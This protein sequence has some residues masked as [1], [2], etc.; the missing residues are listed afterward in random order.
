[1]SDTNRLKVSE[2][3]FDTIKADLKSFMK[4][5][6][7][8]EDYNFEGSALSSMLDVMS[9]VTH[10]NAI[11]AN[12]AINETFLDSARLR[13]S[14]VSHAKMLGYTPRSSYP[15]VAYLTIEVNNPSGVLAE[16]GSYLPLIMTK[17]T[18]FTSTID[19]VSY[20]FVND[21]TVTTTRDSA[22]KYIFTNIKILQGSYKS[23]EYVY[24]SASAEAYVIPFDNAVTSELTVKIKASDSNAATETFESAVNVTA[25]TSASKVYFLEESRTGLF[26]VKFGDG[27]LGKKL[28]NGNIIQLETLI[29]NNDAANGASVFALA[30]TI[31]GNTNVTLTVVQKAAGGSVKEDLESIKFNAPLSFVSQNRAVTPDDYKTIIQNNYA[32]IDAITVWGGEDNDPPDYGKVYISIKPK[33]S[34]VLTANDKTLIISQYLKPKNVVSITPTIVDPKYTYIYLD[35]FFKYNPNVTALSADAIAATIRETIR[36]YNTDQLKRFDG[37]FR[38]SNVN[39]KI[40]ETSIA[41]LNSVVRVKMKKRIVPVSTTETKYDVT[42]S[43]PI[44]NTNSSTQ[45]ITST[46]FVHNGNTGCK[47]RDRVDSAGARRIQIVKGSG[48]TEV[49]V[50]NNAGTIEPTTGKISFTATIDSFTGT[51]IEVTADPDSNDLAPKRNELLTILVDECTITGEVDTMITG[52]TS[53]GVEYTTTSRHE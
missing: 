31:A 14:V 39:A 25:V 49:I 29:T 10:Y 51:Y 44:Y 36:L 16:D 23:T 34:E 24:D 1:M 45:I 30:G 19:G 42:Y 17:G 15:A 4:E 22:G 6:S 48:T 50:E 37:V 27:V 40:D 41:I 52:G 5:Q 3:D 12:F 7:T 47:L 28:D 8:F 20:K 21:Q 9:Y 53:A 18:V 38:Y 11:N 32:N 13:P 35:V 2:M 43:S 33:D 46:E 26:E